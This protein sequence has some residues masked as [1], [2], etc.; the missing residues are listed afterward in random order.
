MSSATSKSLTTRS[1]FGG[2][3]VGVMYVPGCKYV[4]LVQ[5]GSFYTVYSNLEKANVKIG[6][7]LKTKQTLGTL[8]TTATNN[9]VHFEVWKDKLKMDPSIWVNK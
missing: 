8:A 2:N 7:V 6:D 1:V 9:E 3:V 5:H 4:V